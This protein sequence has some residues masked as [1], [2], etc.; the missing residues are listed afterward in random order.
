MDFSYQSLDDYPRTLSSSWFRP[1]SIVCE[2]F[3][4]LSLNSDV[5]LLEK[6][7]FLDF[8]LPLLV[9]IEG[10]SISLYKSKGFWSLFWLLVVTTLCIL[11]GETFNLESKYYVMLVTVLTFMSSVT[12][13]R[14]RFR[15]EIKALIYRVLKHL[16]FYLM[17]IFHKANKI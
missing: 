10:D 17:R 13:D 5:H 1:L 12:F 16:L 4:T 15:L 14:F 8:V 11:L 7:S 9:Y 3:F 6:I 2:G